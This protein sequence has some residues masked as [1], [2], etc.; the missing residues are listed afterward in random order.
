LQYEGSR[1]NNKLVGTGKTKG[2]KTFIKTGR[3]EGYRKRKNLKK[4]KR[5]SPTS[6]TY[7]GEKRVRGENGK[8]KDWKEG[9]KWESSKE[10]KQR[11]E[12]NK[13]YGGR[14]QREGGVSCE[15]GEEGC[16]CSTDLLPKGGADCS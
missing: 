8:L 2:Q 16:S 5:K 11:G 7:D 3:R 6:G 13:G 12:E 1:I 4:K 9:H 14:A 15:N 10:H